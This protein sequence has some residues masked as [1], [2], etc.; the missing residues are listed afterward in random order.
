MLHFF[1]NIDP[2]LI[3]TISSEKCVM[4]LCPEALM[5]IAKRYPITDSS[6]QRVC[7]LSLD[8][9]NRATGAGLTS[10]RWIARHVT[11]LLDSKSI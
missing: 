4:M 1:M 10:M 2:F 9:L 5:T 8:S 3:R 6:R 11:A 7:E